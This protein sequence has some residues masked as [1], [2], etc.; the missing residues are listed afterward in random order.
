MD[1]GERPIK[2]GDS[3]SLRNVFRDSV[4]CCALEVGTDWARGPTSTELSQ[5]PN[6]KVYKYSS[7]PMGIAP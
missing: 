2:L 1:R 5:T 6:A 3:G 7:E 4:I